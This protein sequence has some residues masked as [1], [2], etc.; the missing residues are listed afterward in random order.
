MYHKTWVHNKDAFLH[1]LRNDKRKVSEANLSRLAIRNHRVIII[2]VQR[3]SQSMTL[4]IGWANSPFAC[5]SAQCD[6]LTAPFILRCC[7][8]YSAHILRQFQNHLAV[9]MSER[10]QP[11]YVT[12]CL[13]SFFFFIKFRLVSRQRIIIIVKSLIKFCLKDGSSTVKWSIMN[14]IHTAS[15]SELGTVLFFLIWQTAAK[16]AKQ[17]SGLGCSN[18]WLIKCKVWLSMNKEKCHQKCNDSVYRV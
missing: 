15:C 14:W 3:T 4:L 10:V 13:S 9:C 12:S 5:W 6:K 16:A 18:P 1:R 2:L 17:T 11:C 8:L 7:T